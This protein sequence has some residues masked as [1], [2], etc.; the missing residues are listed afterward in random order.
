MGIVHSKVVLIFLANNHLS[1]PFLIYER[2]RFERADDDIEK[3]NDGD[4]AEREVV[5]EVG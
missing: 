3:A 2:K 1:C 4:G 5:K